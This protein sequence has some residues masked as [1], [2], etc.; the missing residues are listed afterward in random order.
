[1]S[2][3]PIVSNLDNIFSHKTNLTAQGTAAASTLTVKSIV[4]FAINQILLIGELGAE[5]SEVIKTHASTA[6]SG[7]TITLASSLVFTHPVYTKVTVLLYDQVEISHSTDEAGTTKTLLTT[8]LGSGLV[9][10]TGDSLTVRWDDTQFSSGYYW[11]RYKNSINAEFSDY[12]GPIPYSGFEANTVGDI[13]AK[14]LK[15][16]HLKGFSDFVDYQFCLDEIN[17]CLR[18]IAGKLKR[19]SKLQEF[20]YILGQTARGTYRYSLPSNI[21]E[22]ENNKSILNVRIGKDITLKFKGFDQWTDDIMSGV[23]HTQV[24]TVASAGDTTLA[25]D[26]SY[27]F[28][29]SGSVNIYISGT[30]YTLTYT[31]VTRSATAGVLTGIPASGTGAI[32]V[33]IPVDTDIWYGESEGKPEYYTVYGNYV[34]IQLPSATYDNLNVYLDYNTGP[35]KV[36]SDEDTLDAFRYD[37]VLHWLIWAIN[38]QQKDKG[39]RNMQ[40]GDYIQFLQILSD[41]VRNELPAH[42]K[43]SVPKINSISYS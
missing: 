23:V 40:D 19:W 34:Y 15:R 9:A 8:T 21:N 43:R 22:N 38:A 32:T 6:P 37:A 33:T 30:L 20:D 5:D 25:I 41:Y 4:N 26:N 3:K 10:I 7:T 42:R 29:D 35:T 27:D 13:I 39:R 24:R 14:A 31:G 2:F 11:R 1:M 12:T 28:S 18:F 36:D 16:C 17:E